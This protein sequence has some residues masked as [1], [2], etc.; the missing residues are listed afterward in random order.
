MDIDSMT[1]EQLKLR[2]ESIR[3]E[4]N[5]LARKRMKLNQEK[6]LISKRLREER[7]VKRCKN[8]SHCMIGDGSPYCAI[9]DLYTHVD[10]EQECTE[11]E[12][13]TVR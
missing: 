7:K 3:Q 2:R 12:F 10:L 9:Q 5:V 4:L 6:S 13:F 1:I 8:C 11:K